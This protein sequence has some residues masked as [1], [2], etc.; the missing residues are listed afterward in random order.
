MISREALETSVAFLIE[1]L[2][3]IQTRQDASTPPLD[4]RCGGCV[5]IMGWCDRWR[6]VAAKALCGGVEKHASIYEVHACLDLGRPMIW[7]KNKGD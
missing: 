2:D 1:A 3:T 6:L 7:E 5:G 4:K